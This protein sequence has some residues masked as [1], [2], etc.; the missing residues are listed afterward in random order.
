MLEVQEMTSSSDVNFDP[1]E[2]ALWK[3]FQRGKQPKCS[4]VSLDAHGWRSVCFDRNRAEHSVYEMF[5]V[6]LYCG[7]NIQQTQMTSNDNCMLCLYTYNMI[8][9]D[10]CIYS[11]R[12]IYICCVTV[13]DEKTTCS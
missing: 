11:S 1:C 7:K 3:W 9:N 10:V 13:F 2:K 8:Y 5:L 4:A 12:D 6:T